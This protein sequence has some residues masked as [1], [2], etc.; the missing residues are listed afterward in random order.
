[1]L[2]TISSGYDSACVAAL[3]R[4]AGL[5]RDHD[6]P[7]QTRAPDSGERTA[8]ALNIELT[9][10]PRDAWRDLHCPEALFTSSDAKGEDIY[11]AG[12]GEL[13]DGCVL[14]TGFQGG[15]TWEKQTDLSGSVMRRSDRSGLS[16][17]E[18]R[19]HAGFIHC[20]L[21]FLGLRRIDEIVRISN[22]S[23]MSPWDSGGHYTKPIARRILEEAGVPGDA[24]GSEKIAASVVLHSAR[25]MLSPSTQT[26]F[27]AWLDA[28]A[29]DFWRRGAIPPHQLDALLQPL[30]W[31]ARRGWS[32][33]CASA[34]LA[35]GDA[36]RSHDL[37]PLRRVGREG[38]DQLLSIPL[39]D[40]P[41]QAGVCR[42][43]QCFASFRSGSGLQSLASGFCTSAVS[44]I[45]INRYGQIIYAP[46]RPSARYNRG[47]SDR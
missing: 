17:T 19:L 37:A 39:G 13:L 22:C 31:A 14:M 20:P 2:G 46:R 33:Y 5:E 29:K 47:F 1:M 42:R 32:I 36:V 15:K 24:Y 30:R 6:F 45:H 23:D 9:Q 10:I 11:F 12:A 44:H 21:P 16:L 25:D 41:R 7:R 27:L 35:G 4:T 34:T 18:Y 40:A 43:G 38:T 3:W 28:H 26:D 8:R